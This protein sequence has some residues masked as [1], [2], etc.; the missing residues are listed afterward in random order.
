MARQKRKLANF[1][2]LWPA[3]ALILAGLDDPHTTLIGDGKRPDADAPQDRRVRASFLRWCALG[4]D[5]DHRLHETGLQ[6]AGALVVGDGEADPL[7]GDTATPGLD[8]EGCEVPGDLAFM[9]CRFEH[10]P[11]SAPPASAISSLTDRP[12]RAFRRIVSRR[13]GMSPSATPRRRERSASP[14][15]ASAVL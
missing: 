1:G 14:A 11:S 15:P 2:E 13:Q 8:L 7:Q 10:P 9:N 5:K 6:I 3:E 12:C 4:G